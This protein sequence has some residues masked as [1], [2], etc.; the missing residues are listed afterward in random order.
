[1]L[2][3]KVFENALHREIVDTITELKVKAVSVTE[4]DE[5]WALCMSQGPAGRPAPMI[6]QFFIRL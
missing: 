5:L 2:A 3:H 4:P 1:M 6:R